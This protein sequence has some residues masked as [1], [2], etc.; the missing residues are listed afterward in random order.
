MDELKRTVR[1]LENEIERAKFERDQFSDKN[2][3]LMQELKEFRLSKSQYE[4]RV[5]WL[6]DKNEQND[7]KIDLKRKYSAGLQKSFL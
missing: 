5:K 7:K 3:E 1:R 2:I 6:E 4:E